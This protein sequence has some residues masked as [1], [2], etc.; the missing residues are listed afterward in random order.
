M[1]FQNIPTLSVTGQK[2]LDA[3]KW[4]LWHGLYEDCFAKLGLLIASIQDNKTKQRLEKLLE[5][6]INNEDILVNYDERQVNN[7]PFT[8]NIAE[9]TVG[10]LVNSRYS[11]DGKMQ[12]KREGAHNLLQVRTAKYSNMLDKMWVHVFSKPL[13]IAA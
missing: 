12:W 11:H 4:K 6:F 13:K 8:S 9:S 5:Y 10:N 7:L 3:A 1:K 2:E